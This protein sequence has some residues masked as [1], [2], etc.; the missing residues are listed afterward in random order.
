MTQQK[1]VMLNSRMNSTN[2][3]ICCT[4]VINMYSLH[5]LFTVHNT[6]SGVAR[7][8]FLLRQRLATC[9]SRQVFGGEIE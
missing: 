3:A 1:S 6:P 5:E 8:I 7:K 2:K 9:I 4:E